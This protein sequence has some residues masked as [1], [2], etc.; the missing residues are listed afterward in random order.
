[1]TAKVLIYQCSYCSYLTFDLLSQY[2]VHLPDNI[3]L[4]DLPCTGTIS[5]NMLLEAVENG[6]EKVFVLGGTGNDCRFLKGSQRA[7]KRVEEAVKILKEIGYDRATI[8]FYGLKPGDVD[9]LKNILST[10]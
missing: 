2:K 7:Q 8:A 4:T 5:V 10:I 9:S 3:V 1:M 6:F